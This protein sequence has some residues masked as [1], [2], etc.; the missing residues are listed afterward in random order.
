LSQH[1]WHGGPEQ[2]AA[3]HRK[4]LEVIGPERRHEIAATRW[5]NTSNEDRKRHGKACKNGRAARFANSYLGTSI[6]PDNKDAEIIAAIGHEIA[7]YF[8]WSERCLA[9]L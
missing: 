7:D 8:I 5:A 9:P 2:K 3:A 4:R 1:H 6:K